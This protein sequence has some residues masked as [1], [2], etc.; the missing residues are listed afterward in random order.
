MRK[1]FLLSV[2]AL[3]S[4]S[5]FAQQKKMV[6]FDKPIHDF[7]KIVEGQGNGGKVTAVFKFTNI[8]TTPIF[9]ESA[10]AS[11]GL[12][13]SFGRLVEAYCSRRNGRNTCYLQYYR[14]SGY[15]Q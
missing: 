1:L 4:V 2:V 14:S 15:F 10:R 12:Y 11:C 13:Y 5:L 8:G 7:G 6:E 9:I 3:L